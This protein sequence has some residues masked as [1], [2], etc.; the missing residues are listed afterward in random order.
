MLI[1]F[2]LIYEMTLFIRESSILDGTILLVS[3]FY[4]LL[5]HLNIIYQFTFLYVEAEFIAILLFETY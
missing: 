3:G 4:L 5:G 2:N 1:V